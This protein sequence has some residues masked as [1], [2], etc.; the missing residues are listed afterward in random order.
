LQTLEAAIN[1]AYAYSK[2][3]LSNPTKSFLN[4]SKNSLDQ[5]ASLSRTDLLR[6]TKALNYLSSFD[7]SAF[8]PKIVGY[9][10]QHHAQFTVEEALEALH[11]L[12][13]HNL[14]EAKEFSS[15]LKI[16]NTLEVDNTLTGTNTYQREL[17]Y[18]LSLFL[19]QYR[20]KNPNAAKLTAHLELLLKTQ[21]YTTE[22]RESAQRYKDPLKDLIVQGVQKSLTRE[23]VKITPSNLKKLPEEYHPDLFYTSQNK[24]IGLFVGEGNLISSDEN[25]V[26]ATY[27]FRCRVLEALH[28]D[29]VYKVIGYKQFLD[30]D[31]K[32]AK[33]NFA[34]QVD[35]EAILEKLA[36]QNKHS[37]ILENVFTSLLKE[38]NERAEIRSFFE[39]LQN[40][41]AAEKEYASTFVQEHKLLLADRLKYRLAHLYDAFR[42]SNEATQSRISALIQQQSGKDFL[43]FLQEIK[44]NLNA[45]APKRQEITPL[46]W[47]GVVYGEEVAIESSS[48]DRKDIN[49]EI[50][51]YPFL[52]DSEYHTYEDWKNVLD[53]SLN[54][55][56]V[57]FTTLE[58]PKHYHGERRVP[59]GLIPNLSKLRN[60]LK[61][62]SFPWNWEAFSY[63]L[64][65]QFFKKFLYSE[66]NNLSS[67]QPLTQEQ[68]AIANLQNLKVEWKATLSDAQIVNKLVELDFIEELISEHIGQTKPATSSKDS[69]IPQRDAQA[70]V[71]YLEKLS[72]TWILK[73]HY[74][75]FFFNQGFKHEQVKALKEEFDAK[76]KQILN[77][78]SIFSSS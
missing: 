18:D 47:H 58:A 10:S 38:F 70:Y 65:Q 40:Y 7:K 2:V 42:S 33:I 14:H 53:K 78:N 73:D 3:H 74:A 30:I 19:D 45:Q 41:F 56:N 63:K 6:L 21:T 1:L 22:F 37:H 9:I 4:L 11:F 77:V 5:I 31:Y 28:P 68:Q 25:E 12:A 24:N 29:V 35:F 43:R 51:N 55:N 67:Q 61:T 17:L 13:I 62:H 20:A 75:S 27:Q 54:R 66:I 48:K 34:P 69:V 57:D 15:L 46:S 59:Q 8:L 52:W 32:N 71:E 72:R 49:K 44:D 60:S 76:Q 36:P 50:I 23:S 26:S 39:Q 64:P 16:V